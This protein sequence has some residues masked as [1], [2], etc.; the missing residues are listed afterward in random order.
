[1]LLLL[2]TW[3]RGSPDSLSCPFTFDRG[4]STRFTSYLVGR[5]ELLRGKLD[6]TKVKFVR[7]LVRSYSRLRL[8]KTG[9]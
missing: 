9:S 3:G 7:G 2:R 1:M 8:T 4:V 6:T 5:S